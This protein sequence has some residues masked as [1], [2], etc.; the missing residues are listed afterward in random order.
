MTPLV[1]IGLTALVI[2]LNTGFVAG[3]TWRALRAKP[4]ASSPTSQQETTNG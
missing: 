4:S 3:A 1:I 2:G